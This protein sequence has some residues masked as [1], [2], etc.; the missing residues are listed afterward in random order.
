MKKTINFRMFLFLLGF[1]WASNLV[2]QVTT[3]NFSGTIASYTVPAGVYFLEINALGG[4]GGD[5]GHTSSGV[6]GHGA[7]MVGVFEVTPGQVLN[8]L[9]GGIGQQSDYVAGGGGGTFVWDNATSELLIA[10]G[11]GGGSGSTDGSLTYINGMDATITILG[12]NGSG[13]SDGAGVAGMGGTS[14]STPTYAS[15]GTGWNSNGSNGTLH[16]CTYNS[17][18]GERPLVGGALGGGGGTPSL[19]PPNGGFGGGGGGNARCGA[20]GG[21]GGGGYSGGGAG[22]EVI[23]GDFNGGGGGGSFNAG[24]NQVNTAGVGTSNGQVVMTP[25]CGPIA[26][27]SSITHESFGADGAIDLTIT[28]GSGSF[29]FDWDNDGTGDFDDTEDLTGLT[30]GDYTVV[31]VDDN[32]SCGDTTETFTVLN[33]SGVEENELQIDVYPNPT[34]EFVTITYQGAFAYQV[35]AINGQVLLSGTAIN[36]E[37]VSLKNQATGSYILQITVENKTE[38]M[39]IEKN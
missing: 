3:F 24:T 36:S 6:G 35:I 29:T 11:G 14:P 4:A 38:S 26:I 25:T 1:V 10:A 9:V 34:S 39:T 7:Q 19:L 16:G 18:G 5:G 31:V 32:V 21:G 30:G 33:I 12:T 15:G 2:A 22:G 20:V 27:T 8:I 13:M 28:G 17:T 37:I 23:E